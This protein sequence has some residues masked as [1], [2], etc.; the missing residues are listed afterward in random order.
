VNRDTTTIKVF[1]DTATLVRGKGKCKGK[2]MAEYQVWEVERVTAVYQASA[3]RWGNLQYREVLNRDG[4]WKEGVPVWGLRLHYRA[5]TR[6]YGKLAAVE[7]ESEV[8]ECKVEIREEEATGSKGRAIHKAE[9]GD[10]DSYVVQ[11]CM[12]GL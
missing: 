11:H 7:D 9:G 10:Q 3:V 8:M 12:E 4:E 2:Y 5:R 1:R 6:C